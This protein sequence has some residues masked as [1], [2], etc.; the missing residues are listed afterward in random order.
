MKIL[1]AYGILD[2]SPI[3][4]SEFLRRLRMSH[5][6]E[7]GIRQSYTV[8]GLCKEQPVW[9]VIVDKVKA[10]PKVSCDRGHSVLFV[11]D[12]RAA[13]STTNL[14]ISLWP[15]HRS[16]DTLAAF[17]TSLVIASKN[18]EGWDLI[19]KEPSTLDYVNSATKPSLVNKLQTEVYKLTPYS[20]RKE[21]QQLMIAYLAGTAS[22]SAMHKKLK[23]SLKLQRLAELL[24]LPKAKE[25]REAV[26][27]L[28][29]SSVEEVAKK[30]GFE[31]FELLYLSRSNSKTISESTTK[32]KR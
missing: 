29:N 9:P 23:S 21:V 14:S 19:S 8:D 15:D 18:A 22:Y 4:V 5:T 17:K 11:C 7:G 13:L 25:L 16:P 1:A 30:T 3:Q 27:M 32:S 2:Y 31:T 24:H 28:G 6:V 12:S 10:I 26:L 20:L